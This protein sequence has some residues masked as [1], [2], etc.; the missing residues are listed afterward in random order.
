MLPLKTIGTVPPPLF[1]L[2]KA[3]VVP[4]EAA[5]SP[6]PLSSDTLASVLSLSL[7]SEAACQGTS[8]PER[9]V[10]KGPLE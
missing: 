10:V 8:A 1:Q 6:S 3:P 5:P 2:L 4:A 7:S 9:L